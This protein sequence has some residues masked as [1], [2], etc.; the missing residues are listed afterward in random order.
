MEA[1]TL[2]SLVLGATLV[3]VVGYRMLRD[4]RSG[5][6]LA[7]GQ[8]V[9]CGLD[10]KHA[11]DL[12]HTELHAAV[13]LLMCAG[14]AARTRRNHRTAYWAYITLCGLGVAA[15]VVGVSGDLRRGA[16]YSL[17]DYWWLAGVLLFPA[18]GLLPTFRRGLDRD[19][20]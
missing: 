11:I 5:R 1:R 3:G 4:A 14:C 8:C 20:D 15:A 13:P 10:T 17:R 19:A 2:A 6:R 16:H 12:T 7:A 9:R 18:L